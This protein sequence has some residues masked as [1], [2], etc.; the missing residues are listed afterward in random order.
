M[1]N[2]HVRAIRVTLGGAVAFL[3]IIFI[4]AWTFN[5]WQGWVFWGTFILLSALS[6]GWMA[7]YD[8]ELL[9]RRLRRGPAAEKIH[10][11][12]I[13]TAV[14]SL[15]AIFAFVIMVLD[16]RFGW[17]PAV[18]AWLSLVGN[19]LGV[20]GLLIYFV[21]IRENRFAASTVEV[22]QGQTVVST[23]PYAVVRHPMYAGTILF[24][25]GAPIALGSWW[26]LLFTPFF[27]GGFAWRALNEERLLC[28]NLPGYAE[29][30]HNVRYR[31]APYVW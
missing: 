27:I 9:E 22:S 17:S 8:K 31:F 19:G 6:T 21:V 14:N 5:Y 24:L 25:I 2:L 20:V 16:H 4:P 7:I 28:A 30:M 10:A 18:P 29:Y 3:A 15:V 12:K 23:G 13:F 1:S 11:Q 26:G